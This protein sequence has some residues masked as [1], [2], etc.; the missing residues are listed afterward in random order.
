MILGNAAAFY[1]ASSAA[2][3]AVLHLLRTRMRRRTV[4][5]LLLWEG[6]RSDPHSRSVRLRQLIDP[7]LFLQ[8]LILVAFAVAIAEPAAVTRIRGVDALAIVVDGSASMRT[9]TEDGRTRYERAVNE[10]DSATQRDSAAAVTAVRLTARPE[11]VGEAGNSRGDAIN[12]LSASSPTW[13]SDGTIDDLADVLAPHGGLASFDRVVLISDRAIADLPDS[14]EEVGIGGGRNR[15]ITAFSVRE[16][17][18]GRGAVA[19]VEILNP[20]EDHEEVTLRIGDGFVEQ[21]LPI[22]LSPAS[23]ESYVFPFPTSRGTTFTARLAPSDDFVGDDARY[24]A[25]DRPL[26]LRVRW[27]GER[28]PYILAALEA[29][30]PIRLVGTSDE[31]DLTIVRNTSVPAS[32]SGNLLLVHSEMPGRYELGRERETGSVAIE[33]LDHAALRGL[34]PAGIRVFSA[35]EMS[36]PDEAAVLLSFGGLPLLIEEVTAERSIYAL[37]SDLSSTNLPVTVDFPLLIRNI[38]GQIA[39]LPASLSYGWATVGSPFDLTG[40]G[41]VLRLS[42]PD[43]ADIAVGSTQRFFLPERPGLYTLETDRGVFPI[44]I[45]VAS[46]ESATHAAGAEIA[47]SSETDRVAHGLLPLWPYV[48]ALLTLALLAEAIARDGGWIRER[49]DE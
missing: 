36:V 35:P 19:F 16:D 45:N 18:T 38:L 8:L 40:L 25:L 20:T 2:F 24:F 15:G 14:V 1:L 33:A 37:A 22:V 4:S 29:V 42:D 6:L 7:L 26:S 17:P 28:E 27:I 23:S 34:D 31:A 46:E 32:L 43:G 12:A 44:A 21:S 39:R 47:V 11:V 13:E 3:I 48:A 41:D 30:V 9:V 49:R 10:A 5:T